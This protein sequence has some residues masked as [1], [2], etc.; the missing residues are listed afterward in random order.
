MPKAISFIKPAVIAALIAIM[1]A[2][3]PS[4]S[5]DLILCG[6][7]I[8]DG[9]AGQPFIGDVAIAGGQIAAIAQLERLA[10]M[11]A[12]EGARALRVAG[13]GTDHNY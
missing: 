8:V 10:S 3:S 1:A 4:P 2:C 7:T 6:G 9:S 13:S 12:Q 5:Y 11:V